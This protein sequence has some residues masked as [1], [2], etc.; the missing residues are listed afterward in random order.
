MSWD[1]VLPIAAAVGSI[2]WWWR[3]RQRR[4][5]RERETAA[6]FVVFA[7]GLDVELRQAEGDWRARME[8]GT[9]VAVP[10][11][12]IIDGAHRA[13]RAGEDTPE[14]RWRVQLAWRRDPL[15]PL[16]TAF[17]LKAHG[18]RV[19]PR[20]CHPEVRSLLPSDPRP[21]WRPSALAPLGTLF[22]LDEERREAR[23]VTEEALGEAGVDGRDL[24]GIALAVLRQRFDEAAVSR[25]LG[26]ELVELR[27]ADGCGASR[28]LVAGDFLTPGAELLAALP[29]PDT[30]LLAPSSERGRL[31]TV[32]ESRR[33]L[34]EPLSLRL[35]QIAPGGPRWAAAP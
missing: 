2:A 4:R 18:P 7:E 1:L 20:L 35:I 28:A 25:A 15:P 30:L 34:A 23:L 5:R 29:A 16:T 8:E 10:V 11:R 21:V 13:D 6:R 22:V 9:V 31:L 26:G 27:P 19:L 17:H 14:E 32:L 12:V 24:E 3:S 33:G